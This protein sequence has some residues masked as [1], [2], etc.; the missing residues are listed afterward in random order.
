MTMDSLALSRFSFEPDQRRAITLDRGMLSLLRGSLVTIGSEAEG[1]ADCHV[2][3]SLARAT[4]VLKAGFIACPVLWACYASL[5]DFISADDLAAANTTAA[6]LDKALDSA[7]APYISNLNDRDLGDG[8]AAV[9]A[10][11]VDDDVDM[12]FD[13]VAID[14]GEATRARTLIVEARDLIGGAS[15]DL[16][17][18]MDALVRQIVLA[19]GQPGGLLFSGAATL[20]LWGAIFIN[21]TT[22]SDRLTMAEALTHEA[23]HALLTGLAGGR[24]VTL[25]DS[26]ERYPSPLRE[27]PRPIEGIAHAAFVLARMTM[28]L[29]CLASSHCLSDRERLRANCMREDNISMFRSAMVTLKEHAL[30]TA[31]GAAIF[32]H[33]ETFMDLERLGR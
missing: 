4:E 20:F 8:Y 29:D 30:F 28:M 23:R 1:I 2:S 17:S 24:D 33:C 10:R 6:A 26:H 11:A 15:P 13:L 12:R 19:R 27:E 31:E 16:L 3:R 5:C 18:E 32:G 14:D 25:N 7:P 9:Y 22:I 21:P